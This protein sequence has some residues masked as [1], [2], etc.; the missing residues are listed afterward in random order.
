M[1]GMETYKTPDYYCGSQIN[2][3]EQ[4]QR[5]SVTKSSNCIRPYSKSVSIGTNFWT[6]IVGDVRIRFKVSGPL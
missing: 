6:I 1:L 3:L 4:L 5:Q 2:K